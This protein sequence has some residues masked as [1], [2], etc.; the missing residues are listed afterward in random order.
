VAEHSVRAS[1]LWPTLHTLLHDAAEAYCVD[2]PRPLKRAPFMGVYRFYENLAWKEAIAPRFGL[3]TEEPWSTKLADKKMLVT[4][5]RDL[6]REEYRPCLAKID[7]AEGIEP[8]P[9]KID[10][11][12]PEQS[13]VAFLRR[14]AALGGFYASSDS[15]LT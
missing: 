8:I 9:D 13:E 1:Y 4:E 5:K 10:P 14:Y 6:F 12:T 3:D 7:D 11:W 2:I 15:R